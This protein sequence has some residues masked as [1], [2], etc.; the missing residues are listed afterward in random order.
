MS[1]FRRAIRQIFYCWALTLAVTSISQGTPVLY[2]IGGDAFG[3]PRR[4]TSMDPGA[5]TTSVLFDLGTTADGFSGLTYRASTDEFF[6]V[7]DDGSGNSTLVSFQLSGGGAFTSVL[8]LVV[9]GSPAFNGGM[10][11]DS[12]DGDFYGIANSS[13]GNSNFYRIDT[14]TSTITRLF[15][16]LGQGYTGGVTYNAA[17]DS[18]Y[19]IQNDASGNSTLQL[20]TVVG[21]TGHRTLLF[22]NFG[23]GFYGGLSFDATGTN[24]Y[25]L[26]SDVFAASSLNQINAGAPTSLMGVGDGFSNAGLT[27]GPAEVPEPASFALVAGSLLLLFRRRKQMILLGGKL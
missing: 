7:H 27:L 24:L 23:V 14:A 19:A 22:S 11:Y 18:F 16:V 1:F 17:T 3:I 10:V 25:A 26:N 9:A 13:L 8:A 20:F 21:N 6:A 2:S 5:S 12:A 4:L 15:E